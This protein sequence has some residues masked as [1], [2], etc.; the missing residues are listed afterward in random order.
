MTQLKYLAITTLLL[1]GGCTTDD[2]LS[3]DGNGSQLSDTRPGA[4]QED[5][6]V[7]AD[8]PLPQQGEPCPNHVCDRGLACVSYYGIAG[9]RGPLF[10][11]CE[12]KCGDTSD[13]PGGQA[14]VTI[15]DG[16]GEV[17]RPG[18]R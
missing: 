12:I 3:T 5:S 2:G 6:V 7:V 9:P 8:D 13:C 1:I 11:S 14:C 15:A 18:G 17:C 16:P 4:Q 10:T